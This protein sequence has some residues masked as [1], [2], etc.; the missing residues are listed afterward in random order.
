M[1][2]IRF[3]DFKYTEDKNEM[4]TISDYLQ[5]LAARHGDAGGLYSGIEFKTSKVPF[6][7]YNDA[8]NWINQNDRSYWNVAVPYLDDSKVNSKKLDELNEKYMELRKKKEEYA[9][10]H[11]VQTFKSE[12]IGCKKCSSKLA[13]K[14]L[15]GQACP[16]CGEDLRGQTTLDTL[17][18]Y[19]K[20]MKENQEKQLEEK[21]KLSA[22]A[23]KRWLIK[24]EFHC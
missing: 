8:Y 15:R 21:R 3:E 4:R 7:T 11:S 23:E 12:L 13:R 22:K 18:N 10:A 2:D 6:K 17:A 16:L 24:I 14:Y 1:H 20:R 19:D 5:R 9:K